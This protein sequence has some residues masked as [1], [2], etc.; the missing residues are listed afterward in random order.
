MS[1]SKAGKAM[2][3]GLACHSSEPAECRM[4]CVCVGGLNLLIV[5]YNCSSI[6]RNS[7]HC[8]S[9]EVSFVVRFKTSFWHDPHCPPED[10]SAG[11][12]AFRA[13]VMEKHKDG[14]LATLSVCQLALVTMECIV[15]LYSNYYLPIINVG[16]SVS[17][18]VDP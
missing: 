18:Q 4:V 1:S 15:T 2:E 6:V 17:N 11:D 8:H 10:F 3:E 7:S 13:F 5:S 9:V 16:L 14:C 12:I